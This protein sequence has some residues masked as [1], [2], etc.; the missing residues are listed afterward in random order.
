QKSPFQSMLVNTKSRTVGFGNV[1][2]AVGD[3]IQWVNKGGYNQVNFPLT[4]GFTELPDKNGL[5]VKIAGN[6]GVAYFAGLITYLEFCLSTLVECSDTISDWPLGRMLDL[7]PP[8]ELNRI[9]TWSQGTHT[10]YDGKP[11]LVHELVTGNNEES[12]LTDIALESLDSPLILTYGELISQS[13]LVAQHML[14]LDTPGQFI[15]L[16]FRHSSAFLVAMLGSLMAGKTCVPM[17][18]EHASER[19]VGMTQILGEA[20]P[21]VL[22][23]KEHRTTAQELFGD[24]VFCVDDLTL[25]TVTSKSPV[26]RKPPC[27]NPSDIAIIFF[28]SGS[29]GKPKAVPQRHESIVNCILGM[30]ELMN[31]SKDCRCLQTFN[32]GFDASLVMLFMPL[33]AGGTLVLPGDDMI[34]GLSR[35]DTWMMTP[36]M[37]QAV[38]DPEQY[39][40][41]GTVFLAGEPLSHALA[42]KWRQACDGQ[43]KFVNGYGPTEAIVSHFEEVVHTRDS[44]LIAIGKTIPNVQCYLLDGALHMV[45]VGVIGEI[46]I[47]GIGV[48][49]GYLND[50]Q[51][52]RGVFVP[53][54][55]K[56][57]ILYR[58]GD[59][60]CWLP[61]GRVYCIGRKDTQVKLRGFRIELAE[62]E[63]LCERLV[64]NIQQAAAM[65][66]NK[67]LVTYVSPQSVDVDEVTLALKHAL[68]YYMVPAHI[69]PVDDMPKTRNGKV[70]RRALA[71]YPLPQTLTSNITFVEN[72]SECNDTY[73]MVARLALQALQ[74]AEDHPLPAP[75][76][77]FFA[78]G[79]DSISAVSFS[80]LCRKQGLNVTVAKIFTLQTLGAISEYCET[81]SEK[82]NG[83][84]KVPTLTHFQRWLNEEKQGSANMM[85]EVQDPDQPLYVLKQPLGFTSVKQ[86]QSVLGKRNSAQMEIGNLSEAISTNEAGLTAEC[87]ISSSV[88]PMFTTDKLYGQYQCTLS[89]ML[90]AGFLM[91]WWK[92]QQDS[93]DVDLFRLTDNK[94]V[95]THWQQSAQR[96]ILQSPL[97]WLQSVKE[98]TRNATWSDIS[99][100]D[101]GHP[102]VLFHM[103]DPVVGMNIIRQRQQRLVPL[104]G[105]RRRYD[106]EAMAWYQMD[107]TVTLVV[108]S[109]SS[110]NCEIDE[111]F[112]QKLP[113]LWK[114]ATK[115]LLACNSG[116]A[117]LPSDFPLVPFE[118]VQQLTM[119][120]TRVQTV[121]PLSSL[122]QGFVIESLKDPS[123]YMV[124]LVY[125]LQGLLDIDRYHQA[126]FTVGQRHDAMRVQFH[127][128]QSV[129]VVMREFNLEWEYGERIMS[130]T[131][132]PGYL[133]RMRQRG[134]TDL[135]DEPLFRIQLF[136]QN[137]VLH[138]C[139]IT[140]HHAILD[141]WSIDVVLGEVRRLY[142]G[143]ALTTSAVS[144]GRFLAQTTEID[145]TQ[146]Q[147]FW[148][149]YLENM[150]ATPNLPLPTSENS[151][152]ESVTERLTTSLSLVNTWCSKLGI[153][154]N[155]L[156]RGLWALLLGR[157]LGKDTRE[158]T[159]GVMVTGRDGEID[160]VDEMVGL[161]VNTVPFRATL[162][163]S[164]SVQSWLQDIHTQSGAML[165]HSHVG[166]LEI[167][168]WVNQKPLFQSM[169]VNGKSRVQGM[170]DSSTVGKEGLRWVN[171]G[172]YNQVDYPLTVGFAEDGEFNEMHI[173]LSGQHRSSYYSSLLD[174]LNTVLAKMVVE[175]SLH[176]HLTVGN[177][178][179]QI[180][181]LE[182]ERIQTWSQGK[183]TLYY[184]K[185]RLV[186]D[187]VIQGKLP[188]QLNTVALVSLTPP[189]EFTYYE[190]ISRAQLVA[191]RL[192]AVNRS[193]RYVILFFER[194]PELVLSMLGTLTAGRACVPMDATHTSERLIG[195]YLSLDE[196]HPVVLTSQKYRDTAEKLFDGTII[197][198]DDITKL[199]M[200]NLIFSDCKSQQVTPTD[201][202]FVYF[203][204]GS[205]GKPKAVPERHESV[206][207][208]ILGGCDILNL[209]P[210]CRFLQAMNIGFDSCLLELFTT[211]HSGGTVV[212]QSDN[213]VDSLGKVDCCML[214]PSMLQAVGNPSEYPD[215][216][217]VVTAG[218]PLPLSLA[219]KWCQSQ[220]GQ[221]RLYNTYG[222]TE[223]AVTSHFEQVTVTRDDS[224]VTIGRTIPNVQCY[225]LDDN[226]DMVSIGVM[227]EICIGGMG[228][229]HGYLNDEE[230][231][232]D[233]FVPNPF[234][235]GMLYRTG[236]LGYWL[237]DGR[238]YCMGRKDYQVKLR[239]FRVELGEVES[240]VYKS[241]P[242]VQ[243]AVALVKQGKL[244]VYFASTD[245]QVVSITELL[246]CLSQSLPS[247][248]VPDYVVSIA[249]IPHTSNG[250][251]DRQ[252]L[253]ALTL[254]DVD[255]NTNFVQ[256]DLS[257]MET[258]L[259]TG[260][261]DLIKDILRLA[262]SH[263][264]IR[265][266]S[267]FFKLGGDSITAIQLS[268]RSRR[269][270]GLD[271]QVRDIFHHQGILG[272]L[273]KHASQLSRG[274]VLPANISVNVTR[275]PC[276][277]LQIGMISA[278]IKDRTAYIIQASFTVG[279]PL[280]ILRF[281]RAWSVVV[282][283]NPTL[284]TRFD[285]DK[286]NEQWMQVIMEDIDLQWLKFTDKETYLAQDYKRGFTVDGPF[287]RCGCHPNKHQW[288]LTMHHSITDGWSSGLIFEQVIDIYHK[289]SEGQLVPSNVDNGYAQFAHYVCNQSTETAREFWQH[290]LEDMVEGTLLSGDSTK[291]TTP[292]KAEDSVRYVVDDIDE[293]NQYIVHHGVTL[294]SLLRVVWALVL[295]RYTGREKDVVFGVVVS[296]RNVPVSNVDRI[297][298]LC[299]NTIP[300]RIIL[301]KHQTVEALITSV[302]QGSIRTHGYDCYPLGDVHKW[303]G[304]PANQEM[305][306]T[307]LVVENLPYQS[308]GGLDLQMESVFNPTEYPLSALVYPSQ[309][310]LEISMNYHTSKFTAMFVQQLLDDF[311]HTLRSLLVDTS[312]SLVDLPVHFPELHSFVH[313]PADYPVRHA[314]YYVEQQVRNNPDHRA[315]YDLST[316]QEFTY[317]Q[318][319]TMSHYMAL[320]LLKAVE[321]KS[322]KAD[323]IVGIVAQNTPGLVVAQFAVWKLGLAFVVIDPEYPVDRIQFIM[324]DT[325][326]IA[327]IGHGREPPCSVQRNSP[328]ISLE[329][330]T[331][332]LLS[333]DPLPQLPKITIDRHD[334][335]CVI[336]TSGSTGQPKGVLIEHGSTAHYLYAYQM[337]VANTTSQTISPTLVAPT[338]D[339]SIGEMWTTLSFGGMVLLTHNRDNFKRALKNATRV[340]TT[341]SLL[342]YFDPHEFSHLQQVIMSGEPATLSLIRKWQ[343]GGIPQVVNVYG[344]CEVPIGSHYKIYDQCST[345]TV[346][347]VGQPLPGYKGVIM[348]SWMIPVPVGVIGEMWI[349]G[350]TVARGY[351][352]REELTRERFINTPIWGRLYRTGDL[353]HWLPN[354]DVQFLGRADNQVKVRGF[355][356]ELEEV[357]RVILASV[358]DIGRVCIAYDSEMKIL[359]GFVTPEDAN[360]DQVLDALEDRV[361]HYMVPNSI[362]PVSHFPLSHNGKTDRKALLALPRQSN[363][364]QDAHIFTPMETKLVAVLA[365]VL[366][367]NPTVVSPP[368]DTFFTLGGNSISAM[369]FVARCKNNG[370]HIDLV[371]I[372]RRTTI[373][374][375]AK[376]ACERSVEPVTGIQSTE[377][378]HGPFSLTPTQRSYFSAEVTD[379]HQW[380]VPL[381]MKVT[382]PRNLHV[383]CDI[384]TSLVSHHDMM[385]ARFE[386]VDG[387]W[388][389]CVL[390]IDDDPVKVNEVTLTNGTSYFEV[391]AEANRSMNFTTGPI[392][393]ACVM[394][395]RG[396]QYF[397]LALHHLISDNISMNLLAGNIHTLLNGQPLPEKTLAYA[398]WS[399]NLNGLRQGISFDPHELPSEGE[400]V[401]PPVDVSQMPHS[402]PICPRFLSSHL[403]V[404]TTF[405]LEQF[406]HLDVSVEDIILTGLLLAYTDVFN[407]TSIPLQYTSHGRN[408]L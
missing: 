92:N 118:D 35:T 233:V 164:R 300:C 382:F 30:S 158:V 224:L 71:E 318:L 67:Q 367:V 380:P 84:L 408:A 355:R 242:H 110:T 285:Y 225:I 253:S 117:W 70:D 66:V 122:Q 228:V 290:E 210:R 292:E 349:G 351:L 381:L 287:I 19:L 360:V 274:S 337:S 262:E 42:K 25:S 376:H 127:P 86:W 390:P 346:V 81:E 232:R 391:I 200:D 58:T 166:L 111:K 246:K 397:Y 270:L 173:Q 260:L 119:N 395:H 155:S 307:L 404:T 315:L 11:R 406:G 139:F 9:S 293:L 29:T 128:D 263:P 3:E 321:C 93:V 250:K 254:P 400:L 34:E 52:S 212:L 286:A 314:H 33:Y 172:G 73:R 161:T 141:A 138:L 295:R 102:H 338:F 269:E 148:K 208:Y 386:Q 12:K 125:E 103:V 169:L 261:Q 403:D 196:A 147:S 383:W 341:P 27:V 359:L 374:A 298:G 325:Q 178:L 2:D 171:K 53:N 329:G 230:R 336:Y 366:K 195:M 100:G 399:Q 370:I 276:T 361:P 179:D 62:V 215:L 175:S 94:L 344:P 55:F 50:E 8:T 319:D 278:L 219:E 273:V 89:E 311:V 345:P 160:G 37:L 165:S 6:H 135:T 362:V 188:S 115:E 97:A 244:V 174:Y 74:F 18:A 259:F 294:S 192:M 144:Y 379:P 48:S 159:F 28:T 46:C 279:P 238:V 199:T 157:Y 176:D 231:S 220:D 388:C 184:G 227:G 217:V 45:P 77:S 65:L 43:L 153:T 72:A 288:V 221:V 189:M 209:P 356:V 75:S 237:P 226:L 116:T 130:E 326:C 80:S 121:W 82:E 377:F 180:P 152:R 267:S 36:S 223:A 98:T 218:E 372:N 143:L 23:S 137:S 364:E 181:R 10:S 236:D 177:L 302:H 306:N 112:V 168:T 373:A 401:L 340:C 353:A 21:V 368:K 185:P 38:G 303:S 183:R 398:R 342:S 90:L 389:G 247:F 317:G 343:Q 407:C 106:L 240:A 24:T 327:W 20:H 78:A 281:E 296:G 203:T 134:F 156:V 1:S 334:L 348:D 101:N 402:R 323:Q 312:K 378:T 213:L 216:R 142:E 239:G 13:Q 99:S 22:T 249:E 4:V 222:P 333:I 256:F 63:S 123:A 31:L 283:I 387:E 170:E 120:P 146:S 88:F 305:F 83:E 56:S 187:L 108:Y 59:L 129:Q 190:L 384:V 206:V 316:G 309:D 16:F 385:R 280:D 396:T 109:D 51:R 149:T 268:A 198:V 354:G 214:T 68:P 394:N 113:T 331:D 126:W 64:L 291:A 275:Y 284:R 47:S 204:S 107:G 339:V 308:D 229:C 207:N 375:L 357:E 60:G 154:V 363:A 91:A 61:D 39:N 150:E 393:L 265:P 85:V 197:C 320:K 132:V 193:S 289:L 313:N 191:Q 255:D 248:M 145:P 264:P 17:N 95:N 76:T 405:A 182:L 105:T 140:V 194:S 324:S 114:H 322:V 365:D 151:P 234:G 136:K 186:H 49:Y 14:S 5:E 202:A 350:E 201:L 332:C 163:R 131:E 310:Q 205:T 96:D 124:Q 162:D 167:E 304:F 15:L 104:L 277:P 272:A 57:G 40:G 41:L 87:T 297:T 266:G 235:S 54:P 257:P 358:P 258:E 44:N 211:F 252:Q 328:W 282:D 347:S 392:Y 271:L 26:E 243:Q 7:I 69:I 371:D 335:A 301:E 245:Q 352:H 133:L 32:I 79:G 299:I 251:V 330:L 369:H 241:S